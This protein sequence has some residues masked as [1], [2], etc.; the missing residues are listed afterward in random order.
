MSLIN[1]T[2]QH[3]QTLGEASR[4]LE[5]LVHEV[6]G[7]FGVLVRRVEWAPDRTRV[8]LEGVGFWI[9]MWVDAH[10]VHAT[11]DVRVAWRSVALGTQTD[12]A[13]D[14]SEATTIS[15]G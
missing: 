4:R 6:S 12:R 10:A 5:R 8:K 11:G 7:R 14:F 13:A 2:V 9:E 1:L 3:G 15:R